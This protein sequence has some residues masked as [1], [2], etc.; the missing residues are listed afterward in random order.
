MRFLVN[1]RVYLE[2]LLFLKLTYTL[3]IVWLKKV[4]S[5]EKINSKDLIL[6]TFKKVY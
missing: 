4:I 5:L 2:T 1:R 3:M 6:K